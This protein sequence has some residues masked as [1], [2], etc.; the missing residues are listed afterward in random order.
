MDFVSVKK[1][2]VFKLCCLGDI[3]FI[4]PSINALKKNF[5]E[6][7]IDIIVSGWVKNIVEFVP[8]INK[9]LIFEPPFNNN[10]FKRIS[11]GIK[12]VSRLKNE[13]YDMVLLGH[14]TNYFG[15]ILKL[16]GI[17]YRLGFS[18]T[19]YLTHTAVFDENIN[20]PKRYLNILTKNGLIA[21]DVFPKL[22]IK[23]SKAEIRREIRINEYKKTIGIFPFGG[24]NPG[25]DMDIK[26]WGLQ[27]YFS[28][29]RKLQSEFKDLQIVLFEGKMKN[30]KTQ[31]P[32]G[33]FKAEISNEAIAACDIFISGDTG[34]LHIAAAFA[35]STLSIF[36]PTDP[37]I[38]APLNPDELKPIHKYLWTK[39]KCS[40]CYTPETAVNKK[41]T[42]YW[43]KKNFVFWTGTNECIK[44]ISIEEVFNELKYML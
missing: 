2:L 19:K 25:T 36:G 6:A 16:A 35:V 39:P 8:E 44:N 24:I 15:L 32:A 38:L 14:R 3:V 20:E 12:L 26:R 30:E 34:S 1:I 33:A 11:A 18:Q 4:T 22:I 5:P 7:E 40:P 41:N 23:F 9:T 43:K 37:R 10:L 42:K 27:N 13:N 29:I 28:L 31:V 21:E 17:R